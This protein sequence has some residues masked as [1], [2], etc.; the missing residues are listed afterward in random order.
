M[1]PPNAEGLKVR[2]S[3]VTVEAPVALKMFS[4]DSHVVE[5]ADLWTSRLEPRFRD[6]AP[7][8][9][10]RPDG[11]YQTAGGLPERRV[12]GGGGAMIVT[13]AAGKPILS[14]L[15]YRY[16]DQRPGAYDPRARLADQDLD[17]IAAEVVYPGW[18]TL[19]NIPDF[20]LRAASMRV[21]NDWLAEFCAAAP[22][23][24]IGAATLPLSP[25]R[26]DDTIAEAWRARALGL[27]TVMLPH[28]A[29]L[30]YNAPEYDP[31]W[32][33]L[34]EID[35]P[36]T[37]HVGTGR[38]TAFTH[39]IGTSD[40]IIAATLSKTGLASAAVAL[41]WAGVPMRFPRLRFVMAEGG[42]GWI[43]FTLRFMD[44]WWEDHHRWMQ[45]R[46]E[47][48]PSAYF[49]RQFWATFE[50]DRPGILTLP[51]LNADHLMWGNDYPHTEGTFP[52]S[53]RQIEQDLGDLPEAIRH[54]LTYDNA[55]ALYG[56]G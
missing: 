11:D 14:N 42:I 23:R 26:L 48:P 12:S 5:P 24:L 50:D 29:E 52:N 40:G 45:P 6:G 25:G 37:I 22:G 4:A 27:G 36:V 21:F 7:R 31:L 16:A 13:K 32:A 46:L 1:G 54:K 2:S 20:D 51:L 19:F 8:V 53:L 18:L 38:P 3:I 47:E 49:H 17:C 9:I 30:P 56:K 34:E 43:A 15:T 41:V 10:A 33:A 44:H 35:L 28:V 39:P 55:A